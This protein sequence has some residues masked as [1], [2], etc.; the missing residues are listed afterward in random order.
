MNLSYEIL[1]IKLLGLK[2]TLLAALDQYFVTTYCR[3]KHIGLRGTGAFVFRHE[4]STKACCRLHD[5]VLGLL[6]HLLYVLL[7]NKVEGQGF[8]AGIP[9]IGRSV[10]GEIGP[11]E[12]EG[13]VESIEYSSIVYLLVCHSN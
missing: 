11:K 1:Y 9:Q 2:K 7:R 4:N 10:Y 13:F 6:K 5:L 8:L 3:V 12:V